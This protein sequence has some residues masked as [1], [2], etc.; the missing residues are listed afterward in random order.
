MLLYVYDASFEPL[1]PL[2]NI[3]APW[4]LNMHVDFPPSCRPDGS[5][6]EIAVSRELEVF[7]PEFLEQRIGINDWSLAVDGRI[8]D[9]LSGWWITML[10]HD[11]YRPMPR[12]TEITAQDV[13]EA[14]EGVVDRLLK[15]HDV[16][17]LS[18]TGRVGSISL[19]PSP[20]YH[21]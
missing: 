10:I 11:H 18:F 16:R 7:L 9:E 13:M 21:A 15:K 5:R 2:T 14:A 19:T 3:N 17:A 12:L 8:D 4:L 1:P 20:V 6:F